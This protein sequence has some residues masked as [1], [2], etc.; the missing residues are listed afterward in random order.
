MGICGVCSWW[1]ILLVVHASDAV[2]SFTNALCLCFAVA[3]TLSHARSRQKP[4]L[5]AGPKIHLTC[6]KHHSITEES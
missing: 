6:F 2:R 5:W 3:R 1:S 4:A